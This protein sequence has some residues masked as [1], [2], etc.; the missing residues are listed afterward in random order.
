MHH[1]IIRQK[2][3]E[4]G[5]LGGE[6]VAMAVTQS[7]LLLLTPRQ[8]SKSRDKACVLGCCRLLVLEDSG[9]VDAWYRDHTLST[10]TEVPSSLWK[11]S[12]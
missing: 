9:N 5:G 4:R 2:E 3:G 7:K 8:A 11:P 1:C 10:A 12:S 6:V